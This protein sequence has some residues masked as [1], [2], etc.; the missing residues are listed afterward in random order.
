MLNL[1]TTGIY[2]T[3][4]PQYIRILTE[5]SFLES[6]AWK[7]MQWFYGQLDTIFVNSEQYRQSWSERGIEAARIRIRPRGLDKE[8]FNPE[9]NE[10]DFWAR[11]GCNGSGLRLLF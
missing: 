4:F 2:H 8:L 5:D 11:F 1:E 3:D 9:R 7:Y 10:D 6:L